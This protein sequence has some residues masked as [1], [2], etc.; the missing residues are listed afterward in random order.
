MVAVTGIG[1]IS[2]CGLNVKSNLEALVSGRTGLDTVRYLNTRFRDCHVGEVKADNVMLRDIC[3][4]EAEIPPL[5][6]VMLAILAGREALSMSGLSVKDKEIAD[7][8]NGTT[9]GGMDYTE[10]KY[11]AEGSLE[12]NFCGTATTIIA[13]YLGLRGK[14]FTLSTACSSASNAIATAAMS[15]KSGRSSICLAGGTESLSNFHFNGFRS[16]MVQTDGKCRPFSSDRQGINL[17]EGAA[18]IVLENLEDALSSGRKPIALLVG[19]G[20]ACDAYHPTATSETGTGPTLAMRR[21]LDSAGI[22]PDR[23]SW[24]NAHG[25]ATA[26]NDITELRAMKE[27]FGESIPPYSST[28]SLTGHATSAAG[29]LQAVQAVLA[30]TNGMTFGQGIEVSPIEGFPLPV[31]FNAHSLRPEYVMC[32]A[33]GFGGNNTSLIFKRYEDIC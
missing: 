17:G 24:I 25:T 22:S 14:T 4:L 23:I 32:N 33:F 20:N 5:R 30:L 1:I 29:G 16:L 10:T 12:Y 9:V 13:D 8:F 26:N 27:V 2:A 21:A 11:P 6:S 7:F 28:K 3:G 15:L 18:Y 31:T 19:H